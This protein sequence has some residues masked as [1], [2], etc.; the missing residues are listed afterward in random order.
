MEDGAIFPVTN[1]VNRSQRR[2]FEQQA[3]KAAEALEEVNTAFIYSVF[4]AD[5]KVTYGGLYQN[6][7]AKWETTVD[8][9]V[10]TGEYRNV[11]IDRAFFE[12]SYKP[13]LF[14]K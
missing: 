7:L 9:L 5:S 1:L 8:R 2:R 12:N 14:I 11:L 13:Q 3:I 10:A 6:F 4:N